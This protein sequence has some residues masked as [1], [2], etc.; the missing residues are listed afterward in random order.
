MATVIDRRYNH[1]VSTFPVSPEKEAQ[2]ARRM[3]ALGVREADI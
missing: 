3:A 2:L 1:R